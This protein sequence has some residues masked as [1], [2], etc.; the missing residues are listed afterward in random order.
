MPPKALPQIRAY[1]VSARK[2]VVVQQPQI[3][4]TANGRLLVKGKC[5]ETGK[6]VAVFIS[7]KSGE[8]LM[9]ALKSKGAKAHKAESAIDPPQF[10]LHE[11][12]EAKSAKPLSE[13]KG[14]GLYIAGSPDAKKGYAKRKRIT[15]MGVSAPE[16]V[17][18]PEAPKVASP[19]LTPAEASQSPVVEK[20]GSGR[21]AVKATFG[22]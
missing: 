22:H 15:P 1:S 18:H 14:E 20:K 19:S 8:G 17:Q 11:A 16:I 13:A 12:K 5:P 10:Q 4:K 3:S 21:R 7:Q 6:G 2:M 9:E